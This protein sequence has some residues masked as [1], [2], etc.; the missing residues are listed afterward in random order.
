MK[1]FIVIIIVL[2]AAIA[3][4]YFL[5]RPAP[6]NTSSG[7]VDLSASSSGTGASS[8]DFALE[9]L[10]G[11]TVRLSDYKGKPVMVVFFAT[12]CPPC[13]MEIPHL[14]KIHKRQLVDILAVD[15]GESQ[16]K[17]ARFV[18]E[19]DI[20]YQVLVDERG[21]VGSKYSVS[22]IPTTLFIN[23]DGSIHHRFSGYDPSIEKQVERW[24][25]KVGRRAEEAISSR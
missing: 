7:T 8:N 20:P 21:T 9:D 23:P 1:R 22:G 25:E 14:K 13:K 12:W 15:I 24:L 16:K 11:K 18:R 10:A 19:H 6:V 3:V 17:V 2:A 5:N 4:V